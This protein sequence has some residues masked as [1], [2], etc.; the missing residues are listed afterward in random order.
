[1][2]ACTPELS[3]PDP[4]EA[5]TTFNGS[6]YDNL[7]VPPPQDETTYPSKFL[8]VHLVDLTGGKHPT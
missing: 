8:G 6:P 7:Q 3:S 5:Y 4:Y 2:M 1:M